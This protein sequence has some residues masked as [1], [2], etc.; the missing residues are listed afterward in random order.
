M[1]SLK[2]NS[3]KRKASSDTKVM[4]KRRKQGQLIV[5]KYQVAIKHIPVERVQW[6]IV[7]FQV[8]IKHIPVERVQW[9]IVMKNGQRECLPLKVFLIQKAAGGNHCGGSAAAISLLDWYIKEE[10]LILILERP[11]PC[12]DLFDYVKSKGGFLGEKEAKNIMH[13]LVKAA[14]D[15]HKN[16]VFHRDI[17]HQNV[18]LE[19]RDGDLRVRLIEFGCGTRTKEGYYHHFRGTGPYA[20]P[21]V[22]WKNKYRECPT[23][24]WQLGVLMYGLLEGNQLFL[25]EKFLQKNLNMDL[26]VSKNCQ[27]FLDKCLCECP[28]KRADLEQLMLHP[29]FQ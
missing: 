17:K 20:P 15:L 9:I 4:K 12:S 22:F 13:Q 28:E 23:T 21:E 18:L 8:A 29:W 2:P 3:R 19:W 5:S 24:V 10:E 16:S 25:I 6:I 1:L 26:K 27:D 11:S 7:D 14:V